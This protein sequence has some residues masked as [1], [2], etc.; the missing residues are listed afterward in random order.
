MPTVFFDF[1]SHVRPDRAVEQLGLPEH[2]NSGW[3]STARTFGAVLDLVLVAMLGLLGCRSPQGQWRTSDFWCPRGHLVSWPVVTLVDMQSRWTR[4]Y[5]PKRSG[6]GCEMWNSHTL[7]VPA[8]ADN[9]ILADRL[10]RYP[11]VQVAVD[12]EWQRVK[13]AYPGR[14]GK[15]EQRVLEAAKFS[16]LQ[17]VDHFGCST[18]AGRS[19]MRLPVTCTGVSAATTEPSSAA[20]RI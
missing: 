12:A 10:R 18:F 19:A 14:I 16:G 3:K 15:R 20:I 17:T 6:V 13:E 1:E 2:W 5:Q 8:N 11:A 7:Y 9:A 4:R